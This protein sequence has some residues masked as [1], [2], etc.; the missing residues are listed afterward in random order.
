MSARIVTIL[1][2]EDESGAKLTIEADPAV[3]RLDL[4]TD[5]AQPI[6]I[7]RDDATTLARFVTRWLEET[8]PGPTPDQG[9]PDA[10]SGPDE[11]DPDATSG[12]DEGD[13]P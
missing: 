12:P 4:E 7:D 9:D 6:F 11:G 10:S 8:A 5:G 3:N 13:Q 2:I 1:T